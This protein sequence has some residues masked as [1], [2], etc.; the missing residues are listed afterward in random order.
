MESEDP[1]Q[2]LLTKVSSVAFA[3]D[4][5]PELFWISSS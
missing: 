4:W 1:M 5:G 3:V 2:M